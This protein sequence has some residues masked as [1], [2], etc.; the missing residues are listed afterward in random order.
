MGPLGAVAEGEVLVSVVEAFDEVLGGEED[1]PVVVLVAG[2]DA[3]GGEGDFG[4]FA[5]ASSFVGLVFAEPLD[6]GPAGRIEAGFDVVFREEAGLEDFELE[7]S[8]GS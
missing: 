3:A 8:D 2:D 5:V 7:G 4:W 1:D 6:G